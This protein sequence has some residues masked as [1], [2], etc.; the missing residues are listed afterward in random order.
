MQ[1]KSTPDPIADANGGEQPAR[2]VWYAWFPRDFRSST[3]GWPHVAKSIYRDLLDCEF[4]MGMGGLP[5][6]PA[7]LRALIGATPAEWRTSWAP[8]VEAKFPIGADGLRRNARLEQHRQKAVKLSAKRAEAGKL[9]AAKS[10]AARSKVIPISA[11]G[12]T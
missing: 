11:R 5:A 6:D 10:N 4:D 3:L 12:G 7:N 1:P 8:F 9:G 2:L